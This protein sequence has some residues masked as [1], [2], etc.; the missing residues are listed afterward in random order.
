MLDAT[1]IIA[2]W[3]AE[4]TLAQALDSAL[5]Q[6]GVS[7]EVIVIDDA[8]NDDTVRIAQAYAKQDARVKVLCQAANCG[9]SAAR[10]AGMA[11]ARGR[12]VAVL[13]ADDALAPG[14]LARMIEL[15][16]KRQADAVYDDFEPVDSTAQAVGP[17]HLASYALTVPVRWDLETFLSGCQAEPNRPSLGYLKPI[18]R[19]DFLR[20]HEIGYDEALR[21]GEDFHLIA[22]LLA[23]GGALWV[24]PETGYLYTIAKGSISNRLD[25]SHAKALAAA[26]AAFLTLHETTI[27]SRAAA[28]MRRRMMR[29][30]DLGTAEEVLHSLRA[31]RLGVAT[32]AFLSRPRAVGRLLQQIWAAVR[33]RLARRVAGL[34]AASGIRLQR[35]RKG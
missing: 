1:V 12:W 31:R 7:L 27:S 6:D 18:L 29:L 4:N 2:A 8:S 21:N 5:A 10:N 13:D 32:S 11:I 17:S 26:D 22:A 9:P 14:R 20:A 28:L 19:M 33:Q 24:T 30:G 25:P 15:G 35:D 16:D 23:A 34:Y 3:C